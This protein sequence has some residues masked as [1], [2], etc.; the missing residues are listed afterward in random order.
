MFQKA[1]TFQCRIDEI[2]FAEP[3]FATDPNA[4][5]VCIHVV[6]IEDEAQADW[7]RGEFSENFGKGNFATK[8]QKEITMLTL[9]KVGFEGDDLTALDEQLVGK[10]V[11][12]TIK[13]REYQGKSYFDVAYIGDRGAG[14]KELDKDEM[15]RRLSALSGGGGVAPVAA[16]PAAQS[17]APAQAAA[18]P[19]GNPFAKAPKSPF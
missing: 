18:K 16:Q 2:K 14:I 13:E 1:G 19:A 7:W 3:R 6:N 12:A 8:T 15:K 9:R 11:P 5:D 10:E 17:A 4:F